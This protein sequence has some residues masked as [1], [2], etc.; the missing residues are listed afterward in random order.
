MSDELLFDAIGELVPPPTGVFGDWN[1]VLRRAGI[2]KPVVALP[3]APARRRR[4]VTRRHVVAALL[5]VAVLC[6]LVA[7]PAFGIR[8]FLFGLAGRTDVPFT[9]KKAPYEI[10]REFFDLS[11]GA[12]PRMAPQAIESQARRVGVFR[13][14]GRTHVL[15]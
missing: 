11:L 2:S 9:G 14:F 10:R 6:A 1:D 13:V 7:T 15:Y 3:R 12:P 5:V 8:R 4:R